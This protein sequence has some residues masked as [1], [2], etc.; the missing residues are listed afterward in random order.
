MNSSIV[1]MGGGAKEEMDVIPE[2][3][4]LGQCGWGLSTISS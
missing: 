2:Y 3:L 1:F 4:R